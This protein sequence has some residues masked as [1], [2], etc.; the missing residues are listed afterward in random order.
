MLHSVKGGI[1]MEFMG[2]HRRYGRACLRGWRGYSYASVWLVQGRHWVL[3]WFR[4]GV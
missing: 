1:I 2:L 4:R 3:I